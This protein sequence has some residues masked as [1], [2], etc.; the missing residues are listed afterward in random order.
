MTLAT[1]RSTLDPDQPRS[2]SGRPPKLTTVAQHAPTSKALRLEYDDIDEP[3]VEV[4]D[5][6]GN[7]GGLD[8]MAAVDE[9][10]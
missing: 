9:T 7:F 6:E 10:D 8:V 2:D 5:T 4:A 1:P 3:V